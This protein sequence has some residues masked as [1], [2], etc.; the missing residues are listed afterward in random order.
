MSELLEQIQAREWFYTFELPDGNRTRTYH[1]GELDAIHETR[2]EM[3]QQGLTSAFPGGI[4]GLSAMDLA[5]HQGWFSVRLAQAGFG[6]VLGVEARESHVE[7]S[8]L[9]AKCLGISNILFQCGDVHEINLKTGGTQKLTLNA[10]KKHAGQKY[11]IVGSASGTAPGFK[12]YNLTVPL[13]P[14][15]YLNITIGNKNT[16]IWKNTFGTLDK[17]GRATASLNA[18]ATAGLMAFTLHHAYVVFDQN[19]FPV[20]VSQ[21]IPVHLK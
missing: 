8:N 17:D 15:N 1:H 16:G 12:F 20:K 5:S 18:P 19:N 9:M 13:N 7:D 3:V 14:D 2:W 4:D 11:W 6:R 21:A 10:G